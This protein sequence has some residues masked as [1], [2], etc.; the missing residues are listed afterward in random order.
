MRIILVEHWNRI[1]ARRIRIE[2]DM[3]LWA[4][5]RMNVDE[6]AVGKNTLIHLQNSESVGPWAE[7][8]YGCK[9]K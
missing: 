2:E 8:K 9:F 5:W 7:M 4:P 6:R 3:V 1:F